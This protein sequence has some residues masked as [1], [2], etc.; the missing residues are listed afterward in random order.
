THSPEEAERF[1]RR[2]EGLRVGLVNYFHPGKVELISRE[3]TAETVVFRLNSTGDT[4]AFHEAAVDLAVT[5]ADTLWERTSVANEVIKESRLATITIRSIGIP[6]NAK[7][8]DE[9]PV[10]IEVKGNAPDIHG[11]YVYMTP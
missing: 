6:S 3:F 9:I 11:G 8:G 7:T 10:R 4:G 2:F 1:I 5:M